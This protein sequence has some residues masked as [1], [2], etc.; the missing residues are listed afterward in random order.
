MIATAIRV[1]VAVVDKLLNDHILLAVSLN[2]NPTTAMY[3]SLCA[4]HFP[5]SRLS[6][7]SQLQVAAQRETVRGGLQA[8]LPPLPVRKSGRQTQL[9]SA[10]QFIIRLKVEV[11]CVLF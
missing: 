1:G 11:L 9:W 4:I 2:N 5:D 10:I 6:R 8:P 7:L 3:K